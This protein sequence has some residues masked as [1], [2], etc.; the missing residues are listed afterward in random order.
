MPTVKILNRKYLN[1]LR[2]FY[3]EFQTYKLICIYIFLCPKLFFAQNTCYSSFNLKYGD[4]SAVSIDPQNGG[5]ANQLYDINGFTWEAWFKLNGAVRN[6]SVIIG[7]EDQPLFHDIILGFGWGNTP[8]ALS[9]LVSDDGF[10]NRTISVES[11]QNIAVN[12]W[13]HVAAVCDYNGKRMYLYL[14]GILL[15][16]QNL[17]TYITDHRLVSNHETHIGNLSPWARSTLGDFGINAD[18]DEVRFWKTVRSQKQILDNMNLCHPDPNGLVAFFKADE[19]NGAISKSELNSN[20]LGNLERSGWNDGVPSLDCELNLKTYIN[21][22][23]CPGQSYLTYDKA[24][25]YQI[26][27]L[28]FNGCDSIVTLELNY[29][30]KQFIS[31]FEEIC[32]G[33]NFKGYTSAGKYIDSFKN[34]FG[35]DS[36]HEL[37]LKVNSVFINNETIDRCEGQKYKNYNK[38]GIYLDTFQTIHGCDSIAITNLTYRPIYNDTL[39]ISICEGQSYKGYSKAGLFSD[40]LQS[41]FGCDSIQNFNISIANSKVETISKKLCE[42]DLYFGYSSTGVYTD[43]FNISNG[44]DSIRVLNLK[45]IPKYELTSTQNICEGSSF[46]GHKVSGIYIDTFQSILACDSIVKLNLTVH[47]TYEKIQKIEICE[48]QTYNGHNQAGSYIDTFISISG[49][50]S[51]LV[52]ELIIHPFYNSMTKVNLCEG[53][54]YQGYS[55]SG[56]YIDTFQSIYGCD[57]LTNLEIN[58]YPNHLSNLDISI[59]NGEKFNGHS[60]Q[61]IF[62]DTFT[63]INGCD[64]IMILDLKINPIYTLTNT[65]SIC[66][67][68]NYR[69]HTKSGIYIDS[70]KTSFGCDS[71]IS[72]NLTVQSNYIANTSIYLCPEE[73][74]IF[75]GKKIHAAGIYID[76]LQSISSCDSIVVLDLKYVNPYFLTPDTI[77]CQTNEITLSPKGK[78]LQ[79]SDNSTNTIKKIT[80]SG[81]YW[82]KIIDEHG[83]ELLDSITIHFNSKYYIPNVFSPNYDGLNDYFFPVFGEE[84]IEKFLFNIFD[85]WGNFLFSTT[86]PK[87]K[88]WDGIYNGKE[89][90]PGVY[91]YYCEIQSTYCPKI[92]L[93][94]DVTLLR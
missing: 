5:R 94:G 24:G 88:G 46:N 73:F 32:E 71:L 42:G 90:N 51:V 22:S 38:S 29:L 6:Q 87:L 70:F 40:T 33:Q 41:I 20:F 55:R 92:I 28:A 77:L 36:I 81:T 64:S 17:P 60:N 1:C 63:T 14:D 53:E 31:S 47:P 72:L 52:T 74:Y 2:L 76:T 75:E 19:G 65:I 89:V 80:E 30:Q 15:N 26:K 10:A 3:L 50:D 48:G 79:W 43:T 16:A 66:E 67:G 27:Y 49:C 35:C 34:I 69:G 91:V 18:I 56:I 8:N 13:Y 78:L 61:G 25:T 12:R 39:Q 44:C 37:N 7:T 54:T 57:S 85:R 82:A 58:F 4:K 84:S 62:I 9:F 86:D 23:L 11:S 21:K 68:E 83:C 45:V 59:C 93:K